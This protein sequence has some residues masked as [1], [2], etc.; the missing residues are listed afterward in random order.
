MSVKKELTVPQFWWEVIDD[1]VKWPKFSLPASKC[2]NATSVQCEGYVVGVGQ[3]A[4]FDV[5]LVL[6]TKKTL[7]TTPSLLLLRCLMIRLL[8]SGSEMAYIITN[9]NWTVV[10]TDH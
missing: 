3:K 4:V 7:R 9:N 1:Q 6:C 5:F 10:S 8:T 2:C